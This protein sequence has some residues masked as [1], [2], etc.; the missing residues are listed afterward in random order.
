M[1]IVS[2]FFALTLTNTIQ[3]QTDSV[4]HTSMEAVVVTTQR[5][6]QNITSVPFAVKKRDTATSKRFRRVPCQKLYKA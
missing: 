5:T 1:K 3:A 6:R 2:L 4:L